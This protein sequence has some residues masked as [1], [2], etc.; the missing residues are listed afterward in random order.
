VGGEGVT[1]AKV[2]FVH[3][4]DMRGVWLGKQKK[5]KFFSNFFFKFFSNFSKNMLTPQGN[6]TPLSPPGVLHPICG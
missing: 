3:C 6:S 1:F 4:L 5:F 2:V